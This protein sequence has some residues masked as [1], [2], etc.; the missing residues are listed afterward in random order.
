[1]VILKLEFQKAFDKVKHEV[2]LQMI[3]GKGFGQKWTNRIKMILNSVTSSILLNGAPFK[4]F[5]CK[6][7]VRQGDPLP[8]LL[9]VLAADLLESIINKAKDQGILNQPLQLQCTSDFPIV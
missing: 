3:Q 6:R 9:F 2:I 5:Q 7:G 4:R 8:P 1:M